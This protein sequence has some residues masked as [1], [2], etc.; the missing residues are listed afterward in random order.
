MEK[1]S[2]KYCTVNVKI[3]SEWGYLCHPG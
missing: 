3:E 2:L 1:V